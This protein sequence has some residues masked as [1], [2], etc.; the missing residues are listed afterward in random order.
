MPRLERAGLE[1]RRQFSALRRQDVQHRGDRDG[2]VA[3]GAAHEAIALLGE[4]H[5]IV[6]QMDVAHMRGDAAGEV[7]RRLGDREG[8]AGVEANSNAAGALAKVR[9]LV[10]AEILMVFDRQRPAFVERA[11]PA[12]GERG[13]NIRDQLLPLFPERVAVAAQHRG[14]AVAD[15]L[16]VE[17]AGRAQARSRTDPSSGRS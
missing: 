6:L 17:R 11:R 12:V 15:D 7:E 8:V 1:H 14:Q 4:L 9:Q 3:D 5:P 2:A 10:A 16:G 13:A